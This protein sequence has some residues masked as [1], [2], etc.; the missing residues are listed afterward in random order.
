MAPIAAIVVNYRAYEELDACLASLAA[1]AGVGEIVVVDQATEPG[2]R[3][4]VAQRHPEVRWILRSGNS[5]FG[6]GVNQGARAVSGRLLFVV[7]P[8]SVVKPGTPAVLASYLDM[9]AGVAVAGSRIVDTDGAIQ[10]SARRFPTWST[11]F[12]G[13]T[14][15]LSRRFPSNRWTRDNILTQPD[16]AAARTVDWVSGASMMIRRDA[17]DQVGGFDERY[18]LYWEDADLCRRL[19]NVGWATAYVPQAAVVHHGGRS[20]RARLA[21]LSSFHVSAFRYFLV[22]AGPLARLAAPLVAMLLALRFVS[23]VVTRSLPPRST[24]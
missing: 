20:S 9:H 22:H 15:W 24:S 18:F 6:A 13:R 11:F 2:A 3:L 7:N 23:R 19:R 21:P 8:D 5:G 1:Q 17:F 14:S 10:G 16:D 4:R 12:A